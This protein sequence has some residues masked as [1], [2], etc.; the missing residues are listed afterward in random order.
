MTLTPLY[1]ADPIIRVHAFAA[2]AALGLGAVQ[3]AWRKGDRPHRLAGW[4]W[5]ALMALIASSSFG[6]HSIRQFGP[7]SWIHLLS[8]LTLVALVGGVRHARAGRIAAHRWT[9][10]SLFVFALV[11]TGL[12]TLVPGRIMHKVVFGI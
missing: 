2:A 11:V 5:V 3:L 1:E 9:M 7:F 4:L 10:I 6:I 12:F 8:I